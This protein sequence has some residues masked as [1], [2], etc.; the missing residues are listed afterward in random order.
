MILLGLGF[1]A[2]GFA[3][4]AQAQVDPGV[5]IDRLIDA[6][7]GVGPA[8]ALARQQIAGDDLIGAVATLERLL[9]DHPEA[10]DALL[11]HASLLCRLD[12]APGARMEIEQLS[13]VE[14]DAAAW[15][16]VRAACGPIPRGGARR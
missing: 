5:E 15:A 13:G 4:P 14:G 8:M 2:L 9:V 12:D 11:L 3:A 6:S 16:E 1:A 7:Q 10:D